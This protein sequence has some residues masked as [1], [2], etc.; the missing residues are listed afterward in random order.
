MPPIIDSEDREKAEEIAKREQ[1]ELDS[2]FLELVPALDGTVSKLVDGYRNS[3]QIHGGDITRAGSFISL[4]ESIAF[5]WQKERAILAMI[6]SYLTDRILSQTQ[7]QNYSI[8][9]DVTYYSGTSGISDGGYSPS[10][11]TI[12]MTLVNK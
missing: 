1:G 2:R 9:I 4:E 10:S 5:G 7:E 8:V 6:K 3:F 12:H 11:L